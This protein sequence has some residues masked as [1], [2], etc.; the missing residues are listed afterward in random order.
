M[1]ETIIDGSGAG[2]RT[3]VNSNNQLHV[4]ASTI[5]FSHYNSHIHKTAFSLVAQQT[6]S[7]ANKAFVYIL[8]DDVRDMD[9]WEVCL[10]CA[11][12]EAVELWSVTGTAVGTAY[13][14]VNMHVGTG[15]QAQV[16]AKV[17]NDITGLTK[18]SLIRRY[19]L[20]AGKP[21]N[22]ALVTGL[23]VPESSAFALYAV[24]GSA[25]TDVNLAF[26]F[27]TPL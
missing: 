21:E 17:G 7:G 27:H 18:V 13:N 12:V 2:Y 3:K 14:P 10:R 23:T 22:H 26:D 4:L 16:I 9:L 6:P 19:W 8:N 24:T 11:S 5:P 15:T 1:A 25:L 20:E